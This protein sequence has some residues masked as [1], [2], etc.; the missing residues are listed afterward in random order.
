[1]LDDTMPEARDD[2]MEQPDRETSISDGSL[3]ED[4]VALFDDGRTYIEAEIA[5]QKTRLSF[6]AD[7]GKSGMLLGVCAFAVL[8]LA[9]IALV[10]GAIFALT[11]LISALGATA[12][13]AGILLAAGVVLAAK[14]KGHFARLIEAYEK[15]KK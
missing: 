8:H 1:M 3:T 15:A 12:L 9:L 11:P 5:F 2:E 7:R 10:V 6:A 13:V 14:A 4:I